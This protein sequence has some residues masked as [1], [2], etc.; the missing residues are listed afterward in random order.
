MTVG[1]DLM[2]GADLI[3]MDGMSFVYPSCSPLLLTFITEPTTGLDS[4]TT[5]EIMQS[6]RALT[7]SGQ[8]ASLVALLQPPKEAYELFD[9]VMVICDGE[10]AYFGP[11]EAALPCMPLHLFYMLR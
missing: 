11:R 6:I 2:K 3:L 10:I 8:L 1:V 9:T 4:V 5:V 7:S